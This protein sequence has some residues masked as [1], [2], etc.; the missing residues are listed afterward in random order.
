MRHVKAREIMNTE[1][2]AARESMTLAELANFLTE[3]EISGAPVVDA[4]GRLTG[5]VSL[6]D[7]AR[8]ATKVGTVA[9]DR[10]RPD[11]YL[12][13][14]EESYNPEDVQRLRVEGEGM[15]VRDIMTPDV[16]TVSEEASASEVARLMRSRH[17]HRLL[18]T[19]N[20]SRRP[21]GIISTMDL[22]RLIAED[23]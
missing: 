12:T 8:A 9:P 22:L 7:V 18:V 6:S 14:W 20:E 16:H 19:C 13:G 21:V 4:E 5:V 2:L 11:F 3:N 1:V 23:S 15:L 17:L 10:G